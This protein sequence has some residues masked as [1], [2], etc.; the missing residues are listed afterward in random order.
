[1]RLGRIAR[2]FHFLSFVSMRTSMGKGY[3]DSIFAIWNFFWP[4]VAKKMKRKHLRLKLRNPLEASLRK[5]LCINL[6][7]IVLHVKWLYALLNS[8]VMWRGRRKALK[9]KK[10]RVGRCNLYF[11]VNLFY[12][13]FLYT[14][15]Y[16]NILCII[17]VFFLGVELR[18]TCRSYTTI[19]QYFCPTK[20]YKENHLP[21]FRKLL[22]S[23]NGLRRL[24]NA[25][26]FRQCNL[27]DIHDQ[28]LVTTAWGR[29][30]FNRRP[31]PFK[32][33]RVT[34]M[35]NVILSK[36]MASFALVA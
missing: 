25:S 12:L 26:Q 32:Y 29:E 1:M 30:S 33:N 13:F 20:N 23:M 34:F 31:I 19:F 28:K 9:I 15:L 27:Y 10:Y 21:C 35:E 11:C 5:L 16:G 14:V 3:G 4:N 8:V 36:A 7:W 17:L 18:W 24:I 6:P 22:K 2:A